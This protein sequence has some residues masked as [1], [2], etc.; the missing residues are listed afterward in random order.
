[1]S[2]DGGVEIVKLAR[3]VSCEPEDLRY[4]QYVA[5]QDIRDLREQ[6]TV[7]VFDADRQMLQRVAGAA[8]LIPTKLAAA[9]AQQ[10]LGPLLSA[11]VTGL[12]EPPRAVDIAARL[13]TEF[14]AD[15]AAEL[16][17]RRASRVVAEIPAEQIAQITAEL[18]E[19]GEHIVMGG[20]VG[21]LPEAALRAAVETVDDETLLLTA[22]VID[23][24]GN[25]GALVKLLPEE[26]LESIIR[27]AHEADLWPEALDVLGHVSERQ[28]GQL[29]DLAAAQDDEVLDGMVSAA[30]RDGLWADVLPVT[31]AMN[32]DSRARFAKLKSVQTRDV[33]SSIVG[34]AAEQGLWPELLELLPDLPEEARRH[35]AA[36]G[37]DFDHSV[38]EQIVAA[39]QEYDLREALDLF[40]SELE[41]STQKQIAELC[42]A[43]EGR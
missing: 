33:L 42:E 9:V 22:Y 36:L 31:R 27:T 26:R 13:P 1:M 28:R 35:V 8:K 5:P 41:P 24:K 7:A 34:T 20:F 18:A 17:P 19:R 29:G 30:Q 38:F 2:T 15:L 40:T 12:L 4:L 32:P 21:H 39:A 23:A 3:L 25:L 10:A 43:V 11:R 14:L 37:A 16:D 6:V